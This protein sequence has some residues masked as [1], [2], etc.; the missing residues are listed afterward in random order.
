[1]CRYTRTSNHLPLA[2][3]LQPGDVRGSP[4]AGTLSSIAGHAGAI[5][6]WEAGI[7]HAS[8]PK[9]QDM[10]WRQCC[11]KFTK[12]FENGLY[13]K[14]LKKKKKDSRASSKYPLLMQCDCLVVFP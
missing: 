9:S 11:I 4:V 1:M 12:D 5:P 6:G 2:L 8:Q 13:K 3:K 14:K 10:E 7:P